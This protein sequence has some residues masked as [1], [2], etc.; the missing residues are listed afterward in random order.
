MSS[1]EAIL[2]SLILQ[3]K[4][5]LF[6]FWR[7]WIYFYDVKP[8]QKERK[9]E[10]KKRK[11]EKREKESEKERKNNEQSLCSISCQ[12][13]IDSKIISKLEEKA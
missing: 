6:E 5:T 7:L 1:K 13:I 4:Y 12:N 3:Q 10:T 2:F 11:K 8:L 9:K